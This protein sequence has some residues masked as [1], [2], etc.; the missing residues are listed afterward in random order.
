MGAPVGNRH[1]SRHTAVVGLVHAYLDAQG[2]AA[3]ANRRPARISDA[4]DDVR[5]DIDAEGL[6]LTVT[7]RTEQRLS[8]D[9]DTALATA[10]LSGAGAGAL[11]QWRATRDISEAYAVLTLA[12]LAKLIRLARPS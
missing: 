5:P 4:L 8:V 3:T 2:I 12:D 6:A 11:V 7:S 1:R 10:R 9:L